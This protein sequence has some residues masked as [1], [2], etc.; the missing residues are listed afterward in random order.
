MRLRLVLPLCS[1]ALFA[2]GSSALAPM[3]RAQAAEI[4]P[5]PILHD[6][7]APVTGNPRGDVTIVA[8]TDYNCPFCKQAEPA[9]DKVVSA[10]GH[11]RLVHKDWPILSEASV[12]GAQLALA[13]QYQGRYEAVH[14]ALM[15]IPGRKIPKETM[16]DAVHKSG[17]DM[18]RLDADLKKHEA[19]IK[20]LLARNLA[21]ADALGLQG[22]PVYLIGPYKVAEALDADGFRKTVAD[23]RARG[24]Q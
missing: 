19:D 9:L 18:D 17:V 15:A 8:F 2:L 16:L 21:Q 24:P 13:A 20:A 4:D 7:D 3:V 10:D 11:I 14:D 6:P 1:M 12:Y 23:A 5:Q 22:T